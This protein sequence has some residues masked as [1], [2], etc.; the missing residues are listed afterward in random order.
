MNIETN[1]IALFD[2]DGTLFDYEGQLRNS[3]YSLASA[4]EANVLDPKFNIWGDNVPEYITKR[5]HLIKNI[6][7]WWSG[8]PKL[9][10]GWKIFNIARA[11]GFRIH[12]LTKGPSSRPHVWQEKVECIRKHFAP[13][14]IESINITEDKSIHY[15]RVLVDDFPS[16][17]DGWLKHRCRGLGLMPANPNNVGYENPNVIR[18]DD[19]T[20]EA[21]IWDAL[22]AAYKRD[23]KE[24]WKDY[25]SSK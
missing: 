19:K 6:P 16:Y 1:K 5:I 7:G 20:D 8:L 11:I 22:E 3:L 14:E 4:P 17:M 9:P 2:M 25:W 21:I 10:I 15:G 24:H 18:V 13:G 12:I 23:T